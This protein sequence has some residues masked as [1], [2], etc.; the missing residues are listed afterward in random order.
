MSLAAQVGHW[1]M[2]CDDWHGAS[3]TDRRH[4]M[5]IQGTLHNYNRGRITQ[6]AHNVLVLEN[7]YKTAVTESIQTSYY[8]AFLNAAS[9]LRRL[10][11]NEF[12][13]PVCSSKPEDIANIARIITLCSEGYIPTFET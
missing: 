4:E 10:I 8:H 9:E 2:A 1:G 7:D 13:K 3:R 6:A 5:D 11:N 12:H